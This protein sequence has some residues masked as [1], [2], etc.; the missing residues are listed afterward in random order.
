VRDKAEEFRKT[1]RPIIEGLQ[2]Q[3]ITGYR[4]F[5][6]ALNERNIPTANHKKWYAGTVRIFLSTLITIHHFRL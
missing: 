2:A 1:M 5:S 4:P 6:K 3:G